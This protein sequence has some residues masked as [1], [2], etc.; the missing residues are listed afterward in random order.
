M[1][2]KIKALEE[3]IH[4]KENV[5]RECQTQI[6]QAQ[7]ILENMNDKYKRAMEDKLYLQQQLIEELKKGSGV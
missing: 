5:M 3:T 4:L 6:R 2:E 7:S 1:S